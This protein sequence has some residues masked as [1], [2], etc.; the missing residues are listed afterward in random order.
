MALALTIAAISGCARREAPVSTIEVGHHGVE[1]RVPTGWE[2]LDHGQQHLFRKGEAAISLS[3]L[4][5]SSRVGIS[6][7]LGV[8]RE[9]WMAG[10]REDAFAKV[11]A[12]RSPELFFATSEVWTGFWRAWNK[13]AAR[14]ATVDS[15]AIAAAFD[16]IFVAA[17]ALPPV[18]PKELIRYALQTT[19]DMRQREIAQIKERDIG[20]FTWTEVVSW[21]RVTH[22]NPRRIAVH[23]NHGYLLALSTERGLIE[24]TGPA[25]E[26]LLTSTRVKLE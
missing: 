16:S 2:H 13:V 3:D 1:L 19:S 15:S 26:A 10:R 23:D 14:S 4:G 9:L 25:F 20:G 12:L 6:R 11:R 22:G 8:A 5:P 18:A 7:E 17:G 24:Q 21:D